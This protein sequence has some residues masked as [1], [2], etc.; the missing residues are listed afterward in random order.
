M[1]KVRQLRVRRCACGK[2]WGYYLEDDLTAVMGGLAVPV[3]I[4]ND[5]LLEA[6]NQ[7]P[8]EGRGAFLKARVL[9][10]TYDTLRTRRE[11]DPEVPTDALA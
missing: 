3:A 9:P 6:L 8:S 11:P 5:E 10:R 4:E 7:R 1:K 2:S